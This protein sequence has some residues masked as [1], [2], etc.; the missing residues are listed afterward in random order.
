MKRSKFTEEQII[1]IVKEHE[2]GAKTTDLCRKHGM[3]DAT[4]Y[5]W[6]AI[7]GPPPVCKGFLAF[8]PHGLHQSIRPVDRAFAP[9]AM[10]GSARPRPS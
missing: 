3:S 9:L 4:F 5:N 2:A 8:E 1:G 6:K 10:M 7:Y